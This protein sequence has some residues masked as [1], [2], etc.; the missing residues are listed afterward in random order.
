MK[1]ENG[2]TLVSLIIYIIIMIIAMGAM[3]T[4]INEFYKNTDNMEADTKQIIEFNKFNTYFLKEIKKKGNNV[5]TIN[6]ENK[7]IL[8]SSGNSFSLSNNRIYYNDIQVC[9]GV[10]DFIIQSGLNGDGTNT[11]IIY[12]TLKI[13]DFTKSINYK[14]EEI[15]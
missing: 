13:G 5:D 3:S 8:F 6:D 11:D 12:I 7:Y 10:E 4:I 15:Y 1:K 14:I 9:V 2:I